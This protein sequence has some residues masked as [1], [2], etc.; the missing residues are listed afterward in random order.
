[1][2]TLQTAILVGSVVMAPAFASPT[3]D[4]ILAAHRAASGGDAWNGKVTLTL[5][6]SYAGQGLTGTNKSV[7]DL[8]RGAF[9]DSYDIPPQKG[10]TGYDGAKAWEREPSGTVTDQAGGDV[11]PLAITEAY[12]DRNLWW[13]ADRGGARIVS[14]NPKTLNGDTYDVLTVTPKGGT[15]LEAWFDTRSHLLFRTVVSCAPP[16]IEKSCTSSAGR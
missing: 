6:Y 8:T 15:A 16:A 4:D 3:P 5:E 13:R 7:E 2:R 1:M 10:A 12:Q 9:V 11:I 14:E